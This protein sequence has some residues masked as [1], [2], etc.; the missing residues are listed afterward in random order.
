MLRRDDDDT[1]SGA[2]EELADPYPMEELTD[3]YPNQGVRF[4]DFN[5]KRRGQ[6]CW[7][8]GR[9]PVTRYGHCEPCAVGLDQLRER[10]NKR[11]RAKRARRKERQRTKQIQNGETE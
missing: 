3:S 9:Y 1:E 10:G 2:M 8:C 6:G 11:N 5:P 4:R 7:R